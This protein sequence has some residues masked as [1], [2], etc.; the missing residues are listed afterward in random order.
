MIHAV[1]ETRG[2]NKVAR[3]DATKK[4][5]MSDFESHAVNRQTLLASKPLEDA[6]ADL[7]NPTESLQPEQEIIR[8][9]SKRLLQIHSEFLVRQYPPIQ[10]IEGPVQE[11]EMTLKDNK[12]YSQTCCRV[13]KQQLKRGERSPVRATTA[14]LASENNG[15]SDVGKIEEAPQ[16][17]GSVISG[18]H[19]LQF[20]LNKSVA[21]ETSPKEDEHRR[22]CFAALNNTTI[23]ARE[24]NVN[25]PIPN[26]STAFEK[27]APIS[28]FTVSLAIDQGSNTDSVNEGDEFMGDVTSADR[29]AKYDGLDVSN[30]DQFDML[31]SSRDRRTV[32]PTVCITRAKDFVFV[33]QQ[34]EVPNTELGATVSRRDQEPETTDRINIHRIETTVERKQAENKN[35]LFHIAEE[36]HVEFLSDEKGTCLV[37]FL[38]VAFKA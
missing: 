25:I 27:K 9:G 8:E 15:E 34:G 28:G 13:Q 7:Q 20:A 10:D 30:W 12:Y 35:P 1:S 3:N 29:S 22:R 24:V 4:Q 38:C 11:P 19:A 5:V 32:K 2:I 36:N 18:Q 31:Q 16:Y 23:A 26:I 37:I 14:E 6:K 17:F 21:A 33:P